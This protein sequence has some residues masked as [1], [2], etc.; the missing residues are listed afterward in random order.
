MFI[1]VAGGGKLGY[2]LLKEL[3]H[4]NQE[5]VLIEVNKA[6]SKLIVEELGNLVIT[7]D[8]C[9]PLILEKA[10]IGRAEMIMANTGSDE[11]NLIIC[12][13][14]RK[15]YRV[16]TTI[17]RV[18]N[19]KNDD[20]FK[21]LGVDSTINAIETILSIVEQKLAYKGIMITLAQEGEVEIIQTKLTKT[22]PAIEKT[23]GGLRLP[24]GALVSAIIRGGEIIKPDVD[25]DLRVNDV[26]I[27]LTPIGQFVELRDTLMGPDMI[28]HAP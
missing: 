5:V 1:I 22:S 14:A 3:I 20:I 18:N 7:G 13:V 17:A 21:K 8:A 24:K 23:V 4:K 9:D 12:Q 19:P 26:L 28:F 6:R 10:G 15:K 27:T 11:A 2:Y 25:T 16:P